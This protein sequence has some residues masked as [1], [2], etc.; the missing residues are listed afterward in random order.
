MQEFK[1]AAQH[2]MEGM[3]CWL[4]DADIAQQMY[5][6]NWAIAMAYFLIPISLSLF[7]SYFWKMFGWVL[8]T[9]CFGFAIFIFICGIGHVI[10]V[11]NIWWGDFEMELLIDR[12]TAIASIVT[13]IYTSVGVGFLIYRLKKKM[14]I[15]EHM[16][17]LIML[18]GLG[19]ISK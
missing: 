13:A 9:Y 19:K 3:V 4:M 2:N 17:D 11:E 7:L 18:A 6:A 15:I 14:G 5:Y 16:K 1:E 10:K 8:K 12:F